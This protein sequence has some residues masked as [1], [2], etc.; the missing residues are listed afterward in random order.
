MKNV[1]DTLEGSLVRFVIQIL[2]MLTM[3]FILSLLFSRRLH[4]LPRHRR[5]VPSPY[6]S[7]LFPLCELNFLGIRTLEGLAFTAAYFELGCPGAYVEIC[8]SLEM[9]VRQ[10]LFQFDPCSLLMFPQGRLLML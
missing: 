6:A 1:H 10:F 8:I 5:K 4:G 2:Y 3:C 7:H 9:W